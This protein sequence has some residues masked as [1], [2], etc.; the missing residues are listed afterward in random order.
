[1]TRV[2]GSVAWGGFLTLLLMESLPK[3]FLAPHDPTFP[4]LV[5]LVI[6]MVI[7]AIRLALGK[8]SRL[9]GLLHAL[10]WVAGIAVANLPGLLRPYWY[11]L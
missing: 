4:G 6:G 7:E 3:Y 10:G 11:W 5:V 1:M 9:N 2:L 8:T